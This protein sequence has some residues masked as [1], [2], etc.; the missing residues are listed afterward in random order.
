MAMRTVGAFVSGFAAGWIARSAVGSTREVAISALLGI[1][2]LRHE[3][4]RVVAEQ[5]ERIQ[6]LFAE[7]LTRHDSERVSGAVDEA[8]PPRVVLRRERTDAA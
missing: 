2:G 8:S 1:D 3:V 4:I 6:D 5:I 7:G